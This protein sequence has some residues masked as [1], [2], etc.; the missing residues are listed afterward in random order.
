[1]QHDQASFCHLKGLLHTRNK[2]IALNKMKCYQNAFL[3]DYEKWTW[4]YCWAACLAGLLVIF[5]FTGGFYRESGGFC[6]VFVCSCVPGAKGV[7]QML[8]PDKAVTSP[9]VN[10]MET[11]PL[12]SSTAA[13]SQFLARLKH[14]EQTAPPR[15]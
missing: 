14:M 1:M 6:H 9:E 7:G 15:D 3:T 11:V 4:F 13:A 10:Q 12:C 8:S 2:L 5:L